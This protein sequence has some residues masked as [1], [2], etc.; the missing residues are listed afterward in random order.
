MSHDPTGSSRPDDPHAIGVGKLESTS[1]L[2]DRARAGD[3]QALERLFARHLKPLQRWASGRLPRWARD[4]V[5]TDDLVQDTLLQTF[6]RI[7]GF[8]PRGIGALQ[9][10]LRQGVLN[11]IRD[12]LRRK[13]RQPGVGDL[14]GLE[15]D[16]ASSPLEQAIGQETVERYERALGRLTVL[17]QQAIVARVEMGYSYEELA[18]ALGKPTP[19]AA[20]KAAQRALV[21]LVEEMK[22]GGE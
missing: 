20:R 8:E 4:I 3:R 15:V 5:D 19:D 9:A 12:A 13:G 6:K 2:I 1:H 14:D 21:R 18:E 11:R 7:E 22:H 16:H 10:Y 17:D